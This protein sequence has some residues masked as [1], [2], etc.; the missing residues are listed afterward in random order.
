MKKAL[1]QNKYN[2]DLEDILEGKS[3]EFL[4]NQ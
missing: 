3:L 4:Y 2:W 1:E